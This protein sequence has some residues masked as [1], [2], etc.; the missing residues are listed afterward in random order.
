[1]SV[2]IVGDH[3]QLPLAGNTAPPPPFPLAVAQSRRGEAWVAAVTRR[4]SL[5]GRS[6]RPECR[7]CD[8][9]AT[10]LRQSVAL[11]AAST[12]SRVGYERSWCGASTEAIQRKTR[13]RLKRANE[14]RQSSVAVTHVNHV[15][16]T[17]G[18][19]FNGP[20]DVHGSLDAVCWTRSEW[21][22]RRAAGPADRVQ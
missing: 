19:R 13:R 5:C 11:R 12:P 22:R 10:D 2:G 8:R 15:L 21:H 17:A 1:V 4:V 20:A 3:W 18:R 7:R 9:L 16:R 14:R 6:L